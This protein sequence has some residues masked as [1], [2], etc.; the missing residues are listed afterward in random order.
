M[1]SFQQIINRIGKDSRGYG[2]DLIALDIQRSRDHGIP[3]FV[4]IRRKCK[5]TPEIN[6][7]DD[8][9]KIFNKTNVELLKSMY[10]SY[11]DVDFYVGGLL[12]AFESVANPFA[13]DTFGCIIGE[14]YN[15]VMGGDIYYYTHPEN[16]YPFKKAQIDAIQSYAIPNIFCANSGLKETNKYWSLTPSQKNPILSCKSFPPIDLSAWKE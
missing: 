16:P 3:S 10:E 13:G 8:F 14:N 7:F 12:E 5:L 15:N 6:S 11:E 9:S 2:L 4:D 1:I